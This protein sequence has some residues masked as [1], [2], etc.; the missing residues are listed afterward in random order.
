MKKLT[1]ILALISNLC[2]AQL[3]DYITII[4]A[5]DTVNVNDTISIVFTKTANNGSNGMSRLQLWTSTYLQDCM[6]LSSMMLTHNGNGTFI[7]KVKILPIM[8]SG[9]ARIYSNATIGNYKSFYIRSTVGIKEYDKSDIV[10]VKYY[11]IYGK[12]KPSNNEGLTIRITTYSNG[13]QKKEKII[14]SSL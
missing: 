11:D 10:N 7:H 14:Q 9:N 3:T 1:L 5:T 2:N 12:E 6:Y 13:Y 8:G 4:S